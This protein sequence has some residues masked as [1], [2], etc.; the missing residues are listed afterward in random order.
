MHSPTWGR[1]L[2][3]VL[4]FAAM[5]CSD[6]APPP[7]SR[8]EVLQVSGMTCESCAEAIRAEL[9]RLH[10]VEKVEVHVK[11]GR[12]RV[13]CAGVERALLAEAVQS[14][15]YGVTDGEPDPS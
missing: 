4:L 10:G 9:Q 12:V 14:L 2:L 15:G 8:V 11:E 5:A 13:V 1:R 3:V 6:P 7:T